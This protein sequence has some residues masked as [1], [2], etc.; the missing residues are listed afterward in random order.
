MAGALEAVREVRTD[1]AVPL[2]FMGYYNPLHRFGLSRFFEAMREAGGDGVIVPD[3]PL[4]ESGD[5]RSATEAAG[6]SFVPLVAP[7]TPEPRLK[8]LDAAASDFLYCVSLTGVTG[9]RDELDVRLPEYLQRVARQ[10]RRPFV[11]GFG[12]SRPDQVAQVAPPAAGVVIGS[13]LIRAIAAAGDAGGRRR[14]TREFVAS[15]AAAA[16]GAGGGDR[17]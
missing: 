5:L 17:R 3:L 14:A 2:L 12:I 4:E 15:F 8:V 16:R 7:T 1:S 6:I 10:V 9:A 11:V 13:A